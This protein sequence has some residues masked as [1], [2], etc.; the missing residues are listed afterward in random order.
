MIVAANWKLNGNRQSIEI[1]TSALANGLDSEGVPIILAPSHP[2]LEM[3]VNR[4]ASS[5]RVEVAVQDLSRYESGAYTGEVSAQMA[6]DIGVHYAIL[7]HSE[8]RALFAEDDAVVRAKLEAADQAGVAGI[9][10]V[11]ETLDQ[12]QAGQAMAVVESQIDALFQSE[13]SQQAMTHAIIAYEPVWAI[14]T[15][16]SA[17][18]SQA[19][20]MHLHIRSTIA[21][22]DE[23]LAKRVAILYGGSVKADNAND[24]FSCANI[25]GALVGGASLD[26]EQF[27]AICKL[28]DRYND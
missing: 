6:D 28:A 21:R 5:L 18:A 23:T 8:R 7:G 10:C 20:E 17:N 4:F 14:G 3:V 27:L 1:L 13:R 22:Y 16:Q 24:Y 12:R 26:A 11:G 9:V 25:D 19:E 15:G 2:Y